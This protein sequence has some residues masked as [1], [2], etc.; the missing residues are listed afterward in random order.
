MERA[1]KHPSGL[2]R[3]EV[4][5]ALNRQT[6]FYLLLLIINKKDKLSHAWTVALQVVSTTTGCQLL[7]RPFQ[8]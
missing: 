7:L 2:D 8:R 6:V 3:L 1:G 4:A 5:K